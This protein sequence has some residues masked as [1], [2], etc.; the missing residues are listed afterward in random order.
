MC[1]GLNSLL[2]RKGVE[3]VTPIDSTMWVPQVCVEDTAGLVN[4]LVQIPAHQRIAIQLP[5]Q[6]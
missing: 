1:L 5:A 2:V 6:A 4:E 3:E